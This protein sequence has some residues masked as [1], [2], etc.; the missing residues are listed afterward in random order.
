MAFVC[1]V[2]RSVSCTAIVIR[3]CADSARRSAAPCSWSVTWC[4]GA[5]R[6]RNSAEPSTRVVRKVTSM[7]SPHW[8]HSRTWPDAGISVAVRAGRPGGRPPVPARGGRRPPRRGTPS[9]PPP[10]R[11]TAP[12]SPRLSSTAAGRTVE[13]VRPTARFRTDHARCPLAI[14]RRT[15]VPFVPIFSLHCR[16]LASGDLWP[17]A[18]I[19]VIMYVAP[20]MRGW[21][22][23]ARRQAWPAVGAVSPCWSLGG[24]SPDAGEPPQRS[25]P[26]RGSERRRDGH[27]SSVLPWT[28]WSHFSRASVRVA[29]V[30]RWTYSTVRSEWNDCAAALSDPTG[31][32]NCAT[33][34]RP[35]RCWD[36]SDVP[37]LPR[38]LWKMTTSTWFGCRRGGIC[39]HA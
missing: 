31:P 37:S 9:G 36:A 34:Q 4:V 28:A 29:E 26:V 17:L 24:P 15:V 18:Q 12:P 21:A 8:C 33:P 14:Q 10:S 2:D 27:L 32:I 7:V 5:A 39:D 13:A 35:Q 1:T 30:R 25:S 3:S 6:T 20:W 11:S 16:M 38:T 19:I 22:Q 23:R